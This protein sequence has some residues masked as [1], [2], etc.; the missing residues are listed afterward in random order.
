MWHQGLI[1]KLRRNVTSDN[2]LMF[3]EIFLGNR[4]Q[5]VALNDQCSDWVNVN[6][7]VPQ[8]SKPFISYLY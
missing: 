5:R 2:L 8:D 7:G 4:K 6:A 3:H 1:Y